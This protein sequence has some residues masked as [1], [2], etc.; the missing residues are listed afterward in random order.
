MVGQ[1]EAIR[2]PGLVLRSLAVF[3]ADI[4]EE[5][6]VIRLSQLSP[7]GLVKI[8]MPLMVRAFQ[9]ENG[10]IMKMLKEIAENEP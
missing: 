8:A 3:T 7:R 1:P 9:A 4:P 6:H 5:A 10:R 2:L